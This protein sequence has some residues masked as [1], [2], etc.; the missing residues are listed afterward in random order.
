M[1][2]G[3]ECPGGGLKPSHCRPLLFASPGGPGG[4]RGEMTTGCHSHPA[5][6]ASPALPEPLPG[7]GGGKGVRKSPSYTPEQENRN[8]G[9]AR[10]ESPSICTSLLIARVQPKFPICPFLLFP[11]KVSQG[12]NYHGPVQ[13]QVGLERDVWEY[14]GEWDQINR[15]LQ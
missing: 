8:L 5:S 14:E 10:R 11:E 15:D 13:T 12:M 9:A 4:A 1:P 6:E 2:R 3:E 7:H